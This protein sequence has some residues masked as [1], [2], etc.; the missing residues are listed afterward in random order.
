MLASIFILTL[1]LPA[2]FLPV[3]TNTFFTSGELNKMGIC[4][5]NPQTMQGSDDIAHVPEENQCHCDQAMLKIPFG[6]V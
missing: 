5:E 3:A 2:V 1:F 6:C 4:L